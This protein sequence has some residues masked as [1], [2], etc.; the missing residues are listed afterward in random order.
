MSWCARLHFEE[1]VPPRPRE[2]DESQHDHRAGPQDRRRRALDGLAKEREP[3][4]VGMALQRELGL[5]GVMKVHPDEA[6]RDEEPHQEPQRAEDGARTGEGVHTRHQRAEGEQHERHELPLVLPVF[7]EEQV[8]ERPQRAAHEQR[9]GEDRKSVGEGKRCVFRISAR[10]G[11]AARAARTATRPPSVSRGAGPRASPARRP[12]AARGGRS[13][14]RRGGEEVCFSDISAP[15]AS[16]TS[17]T[18]CHSSSQC[19]ERSRSAS[20]PSA[21]PTSSARRNVRTVASVA[22]GLAASD[23]LTSRGGS[24][25]P[26]THFG[27]AAMHSISTFA[28]ARTSAA[29]TT[30][31]RA[32]GALA[33]EKKARYASFILAKSLTSVR[34]T[35]H[36]TMLSTVVPAASSTGFMF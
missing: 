21:P 34:N 2:A 12:R 22:A 15:R 3:G 28:P 10:R 32:G 18:N 11:R 25:R 14:E 4:E 36:F 13:E 26:R 17:G 23:G 6:A 30:V 16:S 24:D 20:V 29:T 19:F 5:R 1:R 33:A 9:E 8:R 27:I 35:V 31:E 7:R